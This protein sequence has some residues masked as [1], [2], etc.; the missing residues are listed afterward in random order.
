M[1]QVIWRNSTT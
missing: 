1:G